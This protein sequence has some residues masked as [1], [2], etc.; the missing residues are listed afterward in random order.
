MV[1]FILALMLPLVV[2]CQVKSSQVK[3]SQVK[4][5]TIKK[6]KTDTIKVVTKQMLK[7]QINITKQHIL[8]LDSLAKELK[9]IQTE[10]KIKTKK[11]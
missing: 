9:K 8:E 1:F 2:N 7:R 6:A 5:D 11:K 3:S 10:T 4:N